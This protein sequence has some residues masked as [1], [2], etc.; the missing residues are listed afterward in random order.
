MLFRDL[1]SGS[2]V[3]LSILMIWLFLRHCHL[4]PGVEPRTKWTLFRLPL[5]LFYSPITYLI[6]RQRPWL[7]VLQPIQAPR[8]SSSILLLLY[9]LDLLRLMRGACLRLNVFA[10]WEIITVD[11]HARGFGLERPASLLWSQ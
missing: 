10:L 7:A 1:P 8:I 6:S 11:V 9:T 5:Q 3:A 4:Q 2:H